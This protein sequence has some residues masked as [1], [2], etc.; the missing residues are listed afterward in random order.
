MGDAISKT[1]DPAALAGRLADERPADI[2]EALNRNASGFA[3][4]VLLMINRPRLDNRLAVQMRRKTAW[5]SGDRIP[6]PAPIRAT[7]KASAIMAVP[8]RGTC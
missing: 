2:A 4:K 3:A 5:R 6:D 8:D 7:F 1:S